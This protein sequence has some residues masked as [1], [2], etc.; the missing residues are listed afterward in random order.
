[1]SAAAPVIVEDPEPL[2]DAGTGNPAFRGALHRVRFETEGH[3]Y[4]W[5]DTGEQ[6]PTSTTAIL[7]ATGAMG[8]PSR[9]GSG[10]YYME[11]GTATHLVTQYWEEGRL[12]EEGLDRDWPEVRPFLES[13]QLFVAKKGWTSDLREYP[14]A[15]RLWAYGTQPDRCG[16]FR[17]D[18]RPWILDIKTG[19]KKP[20]HHLQT[21]GCALALGEEMGISP[22]AFQRGS[23]YLS[24]SG[25]MAKLDPHPN[26]NDIR[27]FA[28]RADTVVWNR[29]YAAD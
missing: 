9:F 1:M 26:P 28:G 19:V 5:Q 29:T 27:Q 4:F 12:D 10:E 16:S 14:T 6:L 17:Y 7:H 22:Q 25:A 20:W 2:A 3:R 23:V 11:R 24:K 21:A 18:D 15:S 8:P 13:W